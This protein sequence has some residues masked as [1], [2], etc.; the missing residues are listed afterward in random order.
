[1]HEGSVT[2]WAT[3]E[4]GRAPLGDSRR[5]KRVVKMTVA[6]ARRP[7]GRVSEVFNRAADREGAYDFLENPH[8]DA[9]ALAASMFRAT[10]ERARA[11]DCV[12]VAVDGSA[13]SLSDENGSKGFGPVGS[14][15]TPVKGLKVM[16]ALAIDRDGVPLGLIDQLFWNRPPTEEGLTI[17][18]RTERNRLRPFDD[19]ETSYF[20]RAAE[21]A[22]ERLAGENIR[23][24]VVI[25]READ[26]RDIL[27]GLHKTGCIFTVRGRWDRKLLGEGK[28]SLLDLLDAQPSLGSHDVD[29]GRTGRRPARRATLDVRAAIVTLRFGARSPEQETDGLRLYAV[30][31]RE[32]NGGHNALDWLLLTNAPVLTAEHA[33]AVID[34]YRARWRI[35]EFHR[36]WKQGEC[37]VE[38]AQLRSV[39]AIIIWA[40]ILSAIATRI[41]R[42]KY[43]ARNKPQEPASVELAPEEIEALKLDQRSRM[44]S[45]RRKVPEM[46]SIEEATRWIAE[47]GGWIGIRNGAPG[48]ITLARGLERLGYLVEG[49]ALARQPPQGGRRKSTT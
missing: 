3:K 43:F 4:F 8:V 20:V 47:I 32:N 7:S 25:D 21:N 2:D 24:W 46:P 23:A 39:D 9:D 35:E 45:K 6:A 36:T 27:L 40:T 49:I 34:S 33:R 22:V 18:Q 37:N 12:Y 38:D 26:N 42:L 14:P 19:K 10:A 30:R 29:V 13:L 16:N 28:Q 5:T 48:S 41:E 44:T 17:A 31:V 11:M 15:N 1:M